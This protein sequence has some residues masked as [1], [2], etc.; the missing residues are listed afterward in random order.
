MFIGVRLSVADYI[1]DSSLGVASAISEALQ[2]IFFNTAPTATEGL[3][4]STNGDARSVQVKRAR[5]FDGTNDYVS[6]EDAD[7]F[8]FGDGST[9]S[10]FSVSFWVN[11]YTIGSGIGGILGKGEDTTPPNGLE[12]LAQ[13]ND[14]GKFVAILYDGSGSKQL[15]MFSD[16]IIPTGQLTHIAYTYDGSSSTDGMQVYING[17]AAAQTPEVIG[18]Y[19]AMEPGTSDLT[20]GWN[21]LA[22]P[23]YDRVFNG[24]I[25]D[26]RIYGRVMT[27]P[28]ILAIYTTP[29]ESIYPN[30]LIDMWKMEGNDPNIEYSAIG[31]ID[32]V[33]TNMTNGGVYEGADVPFSFQNEVGY[34]EGI[35]GNL[36]PRNESSPENGVEAAVT[37]LGSYDYYVDG[38]NGND[39]NDGTSES[40]AWKTITKLRT[41]IDALGDGTSH[42]FLIKEGV[43]AGQH[44]YL[45]T[46]RGT[47][48]VYFEPK[49]ILNWT[50]GVDGS[51]LG[52]GS[53][54]ADIT[55]YGNGVELNDFDTGTGNAIGASGN[56]TVRAYDV[57]T[58]RCFDGF[59]L[60]NTSRG[61]VYRCKFNECGKYAFAHV[62]TSEGYA[63]DCFFQPANTATAGVGVV[64]NNNSTFERCTILSSEDNVRNTVA[65]GTYTNC[66]IGSDTHRI[67]L[68]G[69]VF[70]DCYV[71][72]QAEGNGTSSFT[73]CYG[74]HTARLRNGGGLTYNKCVWVGRS[75]GSWTDAFLTT[76]YNP[77]SFSTVTVT[78][79]IITGYATAVVFADN[80][81][82]DHWVTSGS[83]IDNTAFYNNT[84]DFDT[85]A[86]TEVGVSITNISLVEPVGI[87]SIDTLKM[88]DYSNTSGLYGFSVN[89]V[90]D[91]LTPLLLQYTGRVPNNVDLINSNCGTFDGIN[92]EIDTGIA[93]NS[94]N[95]SRTFAVRF[96]PNAVTGTDSLKYRL[97]TQ[98]FTTSSRLAM[99]IDDSKL[100]IFFNDGGTNLEYG[101]TDLV[102]GEEYTALVSYDWTT[103]YLALYL[104]GVLEYSET[105]SATI[106]YSNEAN[107]QI[108]HLA[109]NRNYSGKMYDVNIFDYGLTAEEALAW[110]N[111]EIVG[112]VEQFPMAEGGGSALY[113]TV[114]GNVATISNIVEAT[115]W[116]GSQNEF[117]Y[118]L[119]NGFDVVTNFNGSDE[120]VDL[121][122]DDSLGVANPTLSCWINM[123]TTDGTQIIYG[124]TF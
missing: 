21:L 25:K 5:E 118:N 119:L 3:D 82:K 80:T 79:C 44:C 77:G 52:S 96:S 69:G 36:V 101:T 93:S 88:T 63:F 64:P 35:S 34:S 10:P 51:G 98:V 104:N 59:S 71:H 22:A 75:T 97:I 110:H 12:W 41:F 48:E 58:N 23:A 32:G 16:A 40:Q 29:T 107:I 73:R 31:G 45:N 113:G 18:V 67:V 27:A 53:S 121:G 30:D 7:K 95:G 103:G 109:G 8:S 47:H 90:I 117:H 78:D 57:V 33:K 89:E 24:L 20:I 61:Y 49:C 26:V 122:T 66:Q 87:G 115:F 123:D 54:D 65:L 120:Y 28:E 111:Q 86:T 14:D 112:N 2:K 13:I 17:I 42:T 100:A 62:N 108:G 6:I 91:R 84:T 74:K 43:Y 81:R 116:G 68:G 85:Q 46:A 38:V 70:T 56:S 37:L 106:G 99:G 11:P 1:R 55:F 15:R 105:L 39:S 92:D 83:T 94:L 76:N 50:S 102:I 9:D 72:A 19:T 4:E 60:H 114:G 124:R